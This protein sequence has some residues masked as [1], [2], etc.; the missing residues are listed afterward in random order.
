MRGNVPQGITIMHGVFQALF[1][2][3]CARGARKHIYVLEGRPSLDAARKTCS[4][5]IKRGATP[6]L[7]SD[8]MAGFLFYHDAVREVVVAYQHADAHG[9][10]CDIGGLIVSIL[11]RRHHVPVSVAPSGRRL[12]FIGRQKDMLS[13]RRTRIASRGIRA[14]VPLVE[15]V[16]KKYITK[17]YA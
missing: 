5:L 3:A 2:D 9:A 12:P 11:A 13:F 7:I 8:N 4:A 17:V 15:W 16:P 14:Y 10:L 1:L 6:T